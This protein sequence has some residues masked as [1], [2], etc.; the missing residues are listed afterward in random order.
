MFITIVD[1][2]S[3]KNSIFYTGVKAK[4]VGDNLVRIQ[5][6]STIV[7]TLFLEQFVSIIYCFGQFYFVGLSC[8]KT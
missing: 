3:Y 4:L 5:K 8:S 6:I 1:R 2:S 7:V